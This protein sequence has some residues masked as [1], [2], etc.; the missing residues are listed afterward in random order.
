MLWLRVLWLRV[1]WRCTLWFV[2][3][4]LAIADRKVGNVIDVVIPKRVKDSTRDGGPGN[5]L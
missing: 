5:K 3:Q 1:L 2:R 4:M